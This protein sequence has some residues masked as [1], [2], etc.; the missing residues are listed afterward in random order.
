MAHLKLT[1]IDVEEVARML[2]DGDP[3]GGGYLDPETGELYGR[4]PDGVWGR[5]GLVDDDPD[6]LDLISVGG[7][8]G[9]H[10]GYRDME[11]FTDAVADPL[12]REE[13]ERSIQGRGAFRRFRDVVHNR[14]EATGKAWRAFADGRS[15]LRALSLL[16]DHDVVDAAELESAA[17]AVATRCDEAL[18]IVGRSLA[19]VIDENQV[20]ALWSRAVAE[21][22]ADRQV[23]ITR[24]G[25]PWAVVRRR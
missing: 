19:L 12:L 17:E 21:I 2:E 24:D 7:Y 22:D 8:G 4:T 20:P 11:L 25:E 1:Q 16:G 3:E 23:L 18:A 14:D 6:E 15:E 5:D 10:E 9:S 13:L